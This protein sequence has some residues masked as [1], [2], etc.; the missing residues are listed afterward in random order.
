[1][2]MELIIDKAN[3]RHFTITFGGEKYKAKLTGYRLPYPI[4]ITEKRIFGNEVSTEISWR[5][6][7]K[8][9]NGEKD[10]VFY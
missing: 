3:E 1:M 6:A 4:I 5:L 10:N 2:E 8:I 9:A 7:E